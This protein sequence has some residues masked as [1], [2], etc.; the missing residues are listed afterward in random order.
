MAERQRP[1]DEEMNDDECG[2]GVTEPTGDL[3]CNCEGRCECD[4]EEGCGLPEEALSGSIRRL[5][6][7]LDLELR[8]PAK[9]PGSP[10]DARGDFEKALQDAEKE[11]QGIDALVKK[12]KEYHC[13]IECELEKAR[14][15]CE[16]L[17]S[18]CTVDDDVAKCIAKLWKRCYERRER[19]LRCSWIEA[20]GTLATTKDCLEQAAIHV[21]DA[22]RDYE[23][24]KNFEKTLKDRLADLKSL[25][26]KAKARLDAKEPKAICA[27][28]FEY[29]KVYE[30][31]DELWLTADW[32]RWCAED[33]EA[34]ASG[35]PC[36]PPDERVKARNGA[37]LR[38]RLI[39]TLRAL[40]VAR[41]CRFCW[42]QRRIDKT[43]D[44]DRR[45]A[46]FDAFVSKRREN[47]IL[48]AFDCEGAG[49]EEE[50]VSGSPTQQR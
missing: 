7:V 13:K 1:R 9:F 46:D 11:Y 18:W 8:K 21:E 43:A 33:A 38:T 28:L 3:L 34:E 22:K 39:E 30:H 29:R 49:D 31:L 32:R 27:I 50:Q 42:H 37:W 23:A 16:D 6:Q 19:R 10:N 25:Y 15:W 47:F 41:Y 4:C 35:G 24:V 12:Y 26:D 44:R 20:E 36:R 45:K 5:L 48:E 40:L 17:M 14:G 2:G